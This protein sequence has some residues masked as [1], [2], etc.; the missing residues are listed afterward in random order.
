VGCAGGWESPRLTRAWASKCYVYVGNN[1]YVNCGNTGMLSIQ[2]LSVSLGLK[3]LYPA[4]KYAKFFN[5]N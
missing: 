4:I 5:S 3:F 2:A 1:Q